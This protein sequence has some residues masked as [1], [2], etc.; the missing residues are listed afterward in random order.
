MDEQLRITL[1]IASSLL[2]VVYQIIV[3]LYVSTV[4]TKPRNNKI[5]MCILA[6]FNLALMFV[7]EWT[8]IGVLQFCALMFVVFS[9]EFSL[10]AKSDA[11]QVLCGAAIVSFHIAVA[12]IPTMV[13]VSAVF[14]LS[15]IEVIYEDHIAKYYFL[16]ITVA[17]LI[18]ALMLVRRIL[19]TLSIQR[20]TQ[21]SK[22]S[23]LLLIFTCMIFFYQCGTLHLI[24]E[25]ILYPAEM[26]I[27]IVTS[28]ICIL[29]FYF[30]FLYSMN[31][32]DANLYKRYSDNARREQE[33]MNL[34][35]KNLSQ[36]IE[37]DGLTDLYNR[38]FVM[39]VLE[40][41]CSEDSQE[42][43][44]LMFVDINALK[45]VNDNYGHDQGDRLIIKIAKAIT[46]ST[47]DNDVVARI[48]GD[49]FLIVL[50]DMSSEE[51]EKVIDRIYEN[52]EMQNKTEK[53]L[54][55]ASVGCIH[56]DEQVKKLGL[57]HILSVAD[58]KMRSNKERF[59]KQTEAKTV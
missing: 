10:L 22:Y 9:I 50:S 13:I 53:F 33:E 18:G 37:R 38:K 54:V 11:V 48:G 47:R 52:I 41:L 58:E 5:V 44:N 30:V 17:L 7:F 57:K 35:K 55:S 34:I 43:F 12:A 20:I 6:I 49:E 3:F 42:V 14:N 46:N 32:V 45:Y 25:S 19:S 23:T 40:N 4:L 1:N 51:S 36:K 21:K 15:P 56:V 59:Y 28:L 27:L 39:A 2:L 31:L 24:S 26:L 29:S 8:Q 16:F